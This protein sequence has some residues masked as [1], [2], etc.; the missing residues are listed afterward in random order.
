MSQPQPFEFLVVPLADG[1]TWTRLDRLA[2]GRVM[3]ALCFEFCTLD[4]L[5]PVTGGGVEDVCK[6][7][8][9]VESAVAALPASACRLSFDPGYGGDVQVCTRPQG[10]DGYHRDGRPLGG[11]A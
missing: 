11:A 6:P 7:C 1:S 5:N 8:G 4:Q 2:D 10:H 3:C 9:R